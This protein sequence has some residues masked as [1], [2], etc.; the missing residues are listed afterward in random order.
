[1]PSKKPAINF[2]TDQWIIDWMKK[3]AEE[4]GRSMS[5][6]IEMLC[7]RHIREYRS[8]HEVESSDPVIKET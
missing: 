5:K 8:M 1:M 7:R 3:I 6:E 2:H 4:N